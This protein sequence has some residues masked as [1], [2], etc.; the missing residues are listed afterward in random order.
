MRDEDFDNV[1]LGQIRPWLPEGYYP[2]KWKGRE[3]KEYSWGEKLIFQWEVFTSSDL[4]DPVILSTYYNARRGPGNRFIFGPCHNYRK[5]WVSANAGKLPV[6]NQL[7]LSVWQQKL[8]IVSVVTVRHDQRGVMHQSS[9][10]SKVDRIVRPAEPGEQF[11]RLP[12]EHNA[13]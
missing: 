5:D 11:N 2:A 9:H 1:D 6:G 4:K 12:I 10:W 3:I 13:F 7:S 8:F